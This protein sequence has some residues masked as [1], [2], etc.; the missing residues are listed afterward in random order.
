MY[1]FIDPNDFSFECGKCD[2]RAATL[3]ARLKDANEDQIFL[4]PYNAKYVTK[5]ITIFIFFCKSFDEYLRLIIGSKHW[6]LVAIDPYN[7]KAYYMDS[8][9]K[10]VPL[11]LKEC[12]KL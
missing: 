2:K 10:K 3:S 8:M 4:V 12:V 7:N 1:G 5:L 11:N 6:M 9:S